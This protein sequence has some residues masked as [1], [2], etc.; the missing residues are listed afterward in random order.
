M[1]LNRAFE[2]L[3][4]LLYRK[5]GRDPGEQSLHDGT[6]AELASVA[7]EAMFNAS[8][9]AIR[10]EDADEDPDWPEE[11]W[12]Q[13]ALEI[14]LERMYPDKAAADALRFLAERRV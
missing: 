13:N 7:W 3:K 5:P 1:Y 9:Q 4:A 10:R 12:K 6:R 2:G 11:P 14:L 8:V